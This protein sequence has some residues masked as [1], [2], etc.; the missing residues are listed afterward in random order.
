MSRV[1]VYTH[2]SLVVKR[3]YDLED[4]NI[5]SI[6]LEVGLPRK[7]KILVCNAYREWKHLYQADNSSGSMKAQQER[8]GKFLDQWERALNENREVIVG[9]DANIDFLKWTSDSLPA[10]I[11][12]LVTDLFSRIFPLGVSQVVTTPTRLWPGQPSSVGWAEK[13]KMSKMYYGHKVP[14]VIHK[15]KD[16]S[17]FTF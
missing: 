11:Q 5:S 3:R 1:V 8:W 10:N 17:L 15:N 14:V 9:M 6:W 4:Q 13:L 7:R 16:I 12:A 2:N